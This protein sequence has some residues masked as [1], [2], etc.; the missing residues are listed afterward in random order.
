VPRVNVKHAPV[1]AH[2]VVGEDANARVLAL[3]ATADSSLID[4]NTYI[5]CVDRAI[6]Q[7]IFHLDESLPLMCQLCS[8]CQIRPN[9]PK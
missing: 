8:Y 7:R 6:S 5:E 2:T 1:R 4:D 9:Q 3:T